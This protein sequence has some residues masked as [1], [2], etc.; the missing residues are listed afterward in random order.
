[1]KQKKTYLRPATH[2]VQLREPIMALTGSM[3]ANPTVG[4]KEDGYVW[5]DEEN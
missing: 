3:N 5:D 1:M 2:P 4:A